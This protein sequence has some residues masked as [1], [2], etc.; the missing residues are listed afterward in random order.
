MLERL[1]EKYQHPNPKIRQVIQD[2]RGFDEDDFVEL[3]I[4]CLDQSGRFNRQEI[5]KIEEFLHG[6]NYVLKRKGRF[7]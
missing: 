3:A 6:E 2:V 1:I 7:D 5:V 4:E